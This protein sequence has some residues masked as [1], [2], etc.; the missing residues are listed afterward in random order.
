MRAQSHC[1][2][3][4]LLSLLQAHRAVFKQERVYMRGVALV[5]AEVMAFG[6]HTVTQLLQVLGVTEGD[7]SSWRRLWSKPR[8]EE[9]RLAQQ[10]VCESLVHVS[11]EEYYVIGTD[12]TQIPRT[13]GRMPGVSWLKSPRTPVFSPG[14][15]R[16]QRFVHGC[17]FTPMANGYSRAIPLRFVPAFPAKAKAG[18]VAA[19][20]EWEA[21]IAFVQWL[22]MQLD[23]LG[24]EAQP[25]LYLADSSYETAEL[26]KALP[27][28]VTAA[29][30]TARNRALYAYLPPSQR[31][32]RRLYGLRVARPADWF[33]QRKG[34]TTCRLLI[35]GRMRQLRY[36]LEGPVVCRGAPDVPL[37]LLIVGGQTTGSYSLTL[38]LLLS[39]ISCV[40]QPNSY[41]VES[42]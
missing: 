16:A 35:R 39:G 13:S 5:L 12:G 2:R 34:Y 6:R 21:G 11:S 17:W 3:V 41:K 32:R 27:P 40:I 42:G 31:K 8:V 9:E 19:C 36:R 4:K 10:L 14:I 24:R 25:V 22:R 15:H 26:W 33:V 7:W 30:R 28:H 29:L 38:T 23:C 18:L 37:F 20:K 1:C